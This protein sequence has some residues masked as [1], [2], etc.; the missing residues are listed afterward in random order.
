MNPYA[1]ISVGV[2]VAAAIAIVSFL[3][4]FVAGKTFA[5]SGEAIRRCDDCGAAWLPDAIEDCAACGS[6][7][8]TVW[9]RA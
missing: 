6:D 7:K 3:A 9:Y 4:D 2:L 8:L 5:K 1:L